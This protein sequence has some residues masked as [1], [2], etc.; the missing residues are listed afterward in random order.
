[1]KKINQKMVLEAKIA[2]LRNKQ[3]ADFHTLKTQYHETI[4]SITPI[5]ILKNSFDS[6]LSTPNLK[7][8]L[9]G[10]ALNLVTSFF[11][12]KGLSTSSE[13]PMQYTLSKII[14]FG[15]NKISRKK[16]SI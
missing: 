14:L 4:E 1:M 3:T 2:Y 15:L 12:K 11:I 16:T 8:K 7:A 6:L 10:K 9:L 13:N 5:N